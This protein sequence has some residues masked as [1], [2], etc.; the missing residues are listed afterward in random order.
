MNALAPKRRLPITTLLRH[1]DHN[2]SDCE[3]VSHR[4]EGDL[5]RCSRAGLTARATSFH[6]NSVDLIEGCSRDN[7]IPQTL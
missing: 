7:K 1:A 4:V 3:V 6:T 2:H 5:H